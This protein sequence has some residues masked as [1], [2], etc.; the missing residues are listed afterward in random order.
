[1]LPNSLHPFT[2]TSR[3]SPVRVERNRIVPLGLAE[4]MARCDPSGDKL[5]LH[6][7][8]T[9]GG[10]EVLP[11]RSSNRNVSMVSPLP[12][13]YMQRVDGERAHCTFQMPASLRTKRGVPPLIGTAK[14]EDWVSGVADLGVEI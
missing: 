7:G 14:M 8:S 6:R 10:P 5:Q 13:L 12:L 2:G 9:C 4:T 3:V 11:L 1:M